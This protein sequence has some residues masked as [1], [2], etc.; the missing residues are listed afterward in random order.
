LRRALGGNRFEHLLGLLTFIRTAHYWTVLHPKLTLEE[1]AIELLRVSQELERLLLQ[2]PEAARCDMGTRLFS[3]LTA[4]RDLDERRELEKAKSAL[5][6][7]VRQKE[8][9]LKEVNHRVKNSLQIVSSM[10]DLQLPDVEGTDAAHA[11]RNAAARI[12]AIAAVHER[13]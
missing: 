8:L 10:L 7:Q 3:E 4:L 13:L 2:G 1:D 12:L 5:E 9:L 6:T 11:M